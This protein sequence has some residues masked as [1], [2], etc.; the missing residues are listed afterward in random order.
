M[1]RLG[2]RRLDGHRDAVDVSGKR[3]RVRGDADATLARR[4]EEQWKR[5]PPKSGQAGC[6][7]NEGRL[8]LIQ[9]EGDE[10]G[11]DG[12]LSRLGLDGL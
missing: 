6:S 12:E 1:V 11:A 3:Q 9:K 10:V 7:A 4:E 2:E 8:T 5:Q